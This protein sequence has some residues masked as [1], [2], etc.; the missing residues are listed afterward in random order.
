[1]RDRTLRSDVRQRKVPTKQDYLEHCISKGLVPQGSPGGLY[2]RVFI[3][4]YHHIGSRLSIG[5]KIREEYGTPAIWPGAP[6][7][8]LIRA[9]RSVGT[10]ENNTVADDKM[11][12]FFL[13]NLYFSENVPC[14]AYDGAL[15]IHIDE[16]DEVAFGPQ[17]STS[18]IIS[19]Y[20]PVVSMA[21]AQCM[22]NLMPH[23]L[24]EY[25]GSVLCASNLMMLM[26]R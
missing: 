25:Q 22:Y 14:I 7:A 18:E 19:R 13:G 24:S 17:L 21:V 11:K 15:D 20:L 23:I 10:L 6:L 5:E 26:M 1:M 16:S 9:V 12:L 8:P 2:N 3:S 4:D